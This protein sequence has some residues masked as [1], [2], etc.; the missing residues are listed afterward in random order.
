MATYFYRFRIIRRQLKTSIVMV[1]HK[2]VVV[3]SFRHPIFGGKQ[4]SDAA[5]EC[6]FR[7][8]ARRRGCVWRPSLNEASRPAASFSRP[9]ARWKGEPLQR[10]RKIQE[11]L[12]WWHLMAGLHLLGIPPAPSPM[13]MAMS[14]AKSVIQYGA[15]SGRWT[16]MATHSYGWVLVAMLLPDLPDLPDSWTTTTTSFFS[17]D[18]VPMPLMPLTHRKIMEW[19]VE[20]CPCQIHVRAC[21]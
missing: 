9:G 15:P 19:L 7:G 17:P 16:S 8:R 10:S 2:G 14:T 20:A 11:S 3:V 13:A 12:Q 4:P 6:W 5:A 18:W 21:L 1:A